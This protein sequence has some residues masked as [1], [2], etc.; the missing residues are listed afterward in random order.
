V[1]KRCP[2]PDGICLDERIEALHLLSGE[3]AT[4]AKKILAAR[5][6]LEID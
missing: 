3:T 1:T 4:S 2:R 5:M 6:R